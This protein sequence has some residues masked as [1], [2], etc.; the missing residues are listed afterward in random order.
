MYEEGF[1]YYSPEDTI[2][3]IIGKNMVKY[4]VLT[5]IIDSEI[6]DLK[7]FIINVDSILIDLHNFFNKYK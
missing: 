2:R 3:K 1:D 7:T 6:T 4:M 5:D